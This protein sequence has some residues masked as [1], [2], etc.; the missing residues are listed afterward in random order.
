MHARTLRAARRALLVAPLL[1][2]ACDDPSGPETVDATYALMRV[3][4]RALPTAVFDGSYLDDEGVEHDVLLRA[5]VGAL[6][7][8]QGGTRYQHHV[9]LSGW[10]DGNP[11]V[12]SDV[13]DHGVCTRQGDALSCESEYMQNVAFTAQIDGDDIIVSQD[14]SGEAAPVAHRYTRLRPE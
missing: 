4:D 2:L 3:V 6:T 11:A 14:L 1:L 8:T 7:L 5:N 10:V 12:V 13:N 9:D